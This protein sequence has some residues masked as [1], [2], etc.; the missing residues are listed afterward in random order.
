MRHGD[1]LEQLLR[2]CGNGV[3]RLVEGVL[4]RG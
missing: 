1:G 4:V 2:G 3:D